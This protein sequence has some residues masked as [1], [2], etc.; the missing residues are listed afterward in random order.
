MVLP[1]WETAF[2]TFF[3]SIDGLPYIAKGNLQMGLRVL[4]YGN[5][6]ALYLIFKIIMEWLWLAMCLLEMAR[7]QSSGNF[8]YFIS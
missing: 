7:M 6:V 1:C 4:G 8:I 5:K 3:L 2:S